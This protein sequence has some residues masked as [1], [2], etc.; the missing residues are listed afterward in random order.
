MCIVHKKSVTRSSKP[1]EHSTV[2]I[3]LQLLKVMT[4]HF[5]T[6]RAVCVQMN[7]NSTQYCFFFGIQLYQFVYIAIE[8]ESGESAFTTYN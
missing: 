1:I 8:S 5:L 4:L 3:N 6:I 7:F 2:H